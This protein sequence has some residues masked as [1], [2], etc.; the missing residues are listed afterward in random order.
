MG[1][2]KLAVVMSFLMLVGAAPYAT[3]PPMSRST[4]LTLRTP[5]PQ[6]VESLVT[7]ARKGNAVAQFRLAH[8]YETGRGTRQSY[9]EAVRWYKLSADQGL[10]QAQFGLARLYED[11]RGVKRDFAYALS[12]YEEAARNGFK[13]ALE[14]IQTMTQTE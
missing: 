9:S 10:P 11:G 6:D 7:S 13:N 12:W 2:P 8:A 4:D 5:S 14:R 3:T 1:W